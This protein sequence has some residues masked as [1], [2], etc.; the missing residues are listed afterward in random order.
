MRVIIEVLPE[1]L[2]EVHKQVS[3]LGKVIYVSRRYSYIVAEVPEAYVV[4]VRALAGVRNVTPSGIVRIAQ[5]FRKIL[6]KK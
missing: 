5:F 3:R 6:F 4:R 2:S 1:Y